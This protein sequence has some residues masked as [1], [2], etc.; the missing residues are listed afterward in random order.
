MSLREQLDADLLEA[1]RS[2]DELRRSALRLIKASVQSEEKS[3]GGV[4]GDDGMVQ[5]LSREAKR[6]KE[7]IDAF[8]EGNRPDLVEK[9][10]AELSII[11]KYLPQQLTED[12]VREIARSVIEEV[13]ASGPGERGKVMGKLMPQVKGKADGK[14]VNQIVGD[15]L[16]GN[17][18]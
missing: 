14:M 13:G 7:S 11:A 10:E 9:E 18:G 4:L 8:R 16:A 17:P 15:L 12:E 5:V 2:K 3:R 1:V 6:R